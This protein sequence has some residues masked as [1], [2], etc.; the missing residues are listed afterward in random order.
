[1]RIVKRKVTADPSAKVPFISMLLCSFFYTGMAP[2]ASGTVA[3][4]A[5]MTVMFFKDLVDVLSMAA[6]S[7]AAFV[8]GAV[9]SKDVIK[10]YGEDPSVI[11]IDEVA[12]MWTTLTVFLLFGSAGLSGFYAIV[13]FLAFRFFD[14]VKVQPAKYFD[15]LK[16]PF[17]VMMDDIIAGIY[18]GLISSLISLTGYTPF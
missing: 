3:S 15:N 4:A 16:S 1:M 14:I 18:A 6:L 5:A 9:L 2:A 8:I 17:G 12:G 7:L 13:C 11:V 10:K